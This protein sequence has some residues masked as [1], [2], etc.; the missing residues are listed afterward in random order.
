MHYKQFTL[1]Q[2]KTHDGTKLT[3]LKR[4]PILSDTEMFI[5]LFLRIKKL[6]HGTDDFIRT[7][8]SNTQLMEV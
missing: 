1:G 3:V 8:N 4:H 6:E 2:Y 5:S 7:E